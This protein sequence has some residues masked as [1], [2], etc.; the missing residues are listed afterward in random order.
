M[1]GKGM[2]MQVGLAWMAGLMFASSAQ[3]SD[4]NV[5]E[6]SVAL[7]R[8][9]VAAGKAGDYPHAEV[10]FR[11]SYLLVPSA[12]TLRNWALT[13]M[14]LGKMLDALGHLKSAL[15]QGNWTAEQRAIVQQNIDDAYAA[16]GHIALKTSRGASVAID[17]VPL[18]G[19]APFE[20]PVDVMP[21]NRQIEARLG[22]QTA[23][24][25]VDATPGRIVELN[26]PI[27]SSEQDVP[28]A[29][30]VSTT[31]AVATA[32]ER[33]RSGVIVEPQAGRT[34][35]WTTPHAVAVGLAGTAVLGVG[36]SI[37]FAVA[38]EQTA[39]DA[40]ALRAGLTGQCAAP[41]SAAGCGAL[42]DKIDTAHQE[43]ALKWVGLG[44]GAAA[45]VG[46]AVLLLVGGRDLS[47][48]TG[49]VRWTP[50]LS[51]GVSGVGGSF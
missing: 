21:G 39:A 29:P 28:V 14:K 31:S 41:G 3:A 8:E 34:S 33:P 23:H 25:E 35:W 45:G 4:A 2:R 47:A 9:G 27:V 19:A 46:A 40:N 24:A 5:Q 38:S 37:Y 10:A 12:S 13:E 42:S 50:M 20:S 48:R 36:L 17:G 49:G 32:P 1:S 43:E 22:M 26:V 15:K 11:V 30:P 7:F 16:T 51:P 6:R 44:V 18:E